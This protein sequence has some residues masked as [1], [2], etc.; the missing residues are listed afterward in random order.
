MRARK[1]RRSDRALRPAPPGRP[2]GWRREHQE[3]FWEGIAG[4]LSSE[5]GVAAGVSPAVGS[6]WFRENG[7][8]APFSFVPVWGI[9]LLGARRRSRFSTPASVGCVRSP[10]AWVGVRRRSLVS[11]AATLLL[12]AE[13]WSIGPR[14]RS[15]IRIGA[16]AARRFPNWPRT[17][18]CVSMCKIV[19]AVL[20]PAPTASWYQ[21]LRCVGWVVV[22][23][24]ERIVG[25]RHRGAPSRSRGGSGSI[26][27]IMSP[28][29]SLTRRSTRRPMCK[30][31]VRSNGNWWRVC[32]PGERCGCRGHGP[33]SGARAS[34][35]PR[36]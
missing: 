26:S 3:R 36:S 5:P 33:A 4:G 30:A 12:V 16:P 28:C 24:P 19:S 27:P 35:A 11:C 7:G 20:S 34:S 9:Y 23:G 22:M 29:E 31:G 21:A 15:G 10:A 17:T 8:M 1:V 14:P 18:P 6:R 13:A 32:A 2:P 25:G